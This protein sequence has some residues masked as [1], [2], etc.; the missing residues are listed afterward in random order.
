MT[1][2]VVELTFPIYSI[3]ELDVY[4]V[5]SSMPLPSPSS[6]VGAVGAAMG[7]TGLCKGSECLE[8]ARRAVK[9]ARPAATGYLTKSPVVLRRIR[10]IL[11]EKQ[12]P[13]DLGEFVSFSDAMS[14]EY[15]LTTSLKVLIIGELKSEVLYLI[16]RIGDSESLA[17]VVSVRRYD[18]AERCNGGVNVAVVRD[19]AR[20][21]SFTLVK[22]L[23][24]A[25]RPRMYALPVV[26]TTGDVYMPSTIKTD[27]GV[28]C[29]EDIKFPEGYGW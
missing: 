28:L 14:R 20:G 5:A 26:R 15:V 23:D 11:E 25:G 16:D 9:I 7:R 22:M 6:I 29:V 13:S 8:A 19:V 18:R 4:Q 27:R 24:E 2:F 1:Y 10:K 17:S 21:G 12:L 3:K